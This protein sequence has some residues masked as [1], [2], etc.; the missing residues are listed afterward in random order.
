MSTRENGHFAVLDLPAAT[1]SPVCVHCANDLASLYQIYQMSHDKP[2]A[3]G[4]LSRGFLMHPVPLFARLS[5]A[6]Y[7]RTFVTIDGVPAPEFLS[8]QDTLASLGY[9]YVVWHK[10]LW[11]RVGGKGADKTSEA[12]V[13]EAFG[14]GASPFYEDDQ[15]RVYRVQQGKTHCGSLRQPR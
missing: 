1:D 6:E 11:D 2:I 5:A 10:G 12:F 7:A 8:A 15:V 13:S 14:E 3:W 4:Y 9:R